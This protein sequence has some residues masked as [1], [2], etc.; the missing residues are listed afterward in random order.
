MSCSWCG[1][2]LSSEA[3]RDAKFCSKLCRQR[4]WR[5][6]VD[7]AERVAGG[8]P[9]RLAYADPP[10]PGLAGYY[11]ERREVDHAAL[12]SRLEEFDGWALSTSAAALPFVL[13]LLQG[14][15]VR[16][17]AWLKKPRGG[18]AWE[19]V[20]VKSARRVGRSEV[21]ARHYAGRYHAF[22]GALIGMKP[23]QFSVWLFK[24]LGAT[25]EDSFNDLFPGSG[26]VSLAWRRYSSRSDRGGVSLD[27][28]D[29]SR[30]PAAGVSLDPA[31][32]RRAQVEATA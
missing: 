23:P 32:T 1:G 18:S 13:S 6:G 8:R 5:F 7:A 4:S 12:V 20:I 29:V 21:D 19:P 17:C 14:R 3:R 26:A 15:R 10:Y 30:S 24:L 2:V 28:R 25:P 27:R 16:V 31:A 9:R 11:P 22:P